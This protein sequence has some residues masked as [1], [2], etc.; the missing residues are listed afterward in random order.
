MIRK[1]FFKKLVSNTFHFAYEKFK[2]SLRAAYATFPPASF[3]LR[4]T[5]ASLARCLR[6]YADLSLSLRGLPP[7]MF[8]GHALKTLRETYAPLTRRSARRPFCFF[9]FFFC[10]FRPWADGVAGEKR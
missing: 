8:M 5:Y 4:K 1:I 10:F 9:F 2:K 6:A 3:R 7:A